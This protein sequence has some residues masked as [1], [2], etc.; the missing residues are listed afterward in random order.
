MRYCFINLEI[1]KNNSGIKRLGKGDFMLLQLEKLEKRFGKQVVFDQANI[2]FAECGLYFLR[3][4]SG[5][6]KT[7]LLNIIAGYEPFENGQ[8]NIDV[9][10]R[11][12][13]I[14]QSY[15]LI[16]EF[17]V[18]EN[19][20]LHQDIYHD[21]ETNYANMIIE[22]LGLET[23][24][25]HYPKELSGGQKQRVGIARALLL[26][27]DII[28]CDEPTESLDIENKEKVLSLLKKLSENKVVIIASHEEELLKDYYDYGYEIKNKKIVCYEKRKNGKEVIVTTKETKLDHQKTR[29]YL[30]KMMKRST[31]M[32][33]LI[34]CLLLLSQMGVGQINLQ[35]FVEKEQVSTLNNDVIYM[36]ITGSPKEELV[37]KYTHFYAVG[38]AYLQIT[39]APWHIE[40]KTYK[41][42]TFPYISNTEQL[43]IIGAKVPKDFNVLINQFVAEKMMEELHCSESD[44]LGKQIQLEYILSNE[45]YPVD[46][47]VSG[48]V[49]ESSIQGKLQIYYDKEAM[50]N[51]LTSTQYI[52]GISQYEIMKDE[53]STYALQMNEKATAKDIYRQWTKEPIGFNV[54]HSI[55]SQLKDLKSQRAMYLLVFNIVQIIL[56]VITILYVLFYAI[57]DTKKN[58]KNLS[59]MISLNLPIRLLKQTYLKKKIAYVVM[60]EALVVVEV[61]VYQMFY[62]EMEL[63]RNALLYLLGVLLVYSIVLISQLARFKMQQV[64]SL[65]NDSKDM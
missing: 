51:L 30:W 28:I 58:S 29:G 27:P 21:T 43:E 17:N 59:I 24:L 64:S 33:S 48:I 20:L 40:G 44:L 3:G 45:K 2:D 60:A 25:N 57:K 53:V 46:F 65:L 18:K 15:E 31:I 19:I 9:N 14:F 38:N 61:I 22:T 23:L 37:D 56:L 12:A 1:V 52:E 55:Y 8:R 54:Y 41:P 13:C 50:L 42:N 62:S 47:K 26:Q 6:G 7:T 10:A 49:K 63:T 35:L 36:T 11:I 16:D 39:F 5:S 34:L 32:Y 4:E